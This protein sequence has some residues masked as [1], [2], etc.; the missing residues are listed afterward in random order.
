MA[1]DLTV[2]SRIAALE[3]EVKSIKQRIDRRPRDHDWLSNVTGSMAEMPEFDAV[4]E[5]GQS[6]RR[7]DSINDGHP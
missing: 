4:L 7:Q 2:E 3:Q 6:L 1:Q 5:I